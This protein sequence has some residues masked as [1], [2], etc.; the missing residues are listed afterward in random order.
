MIIFTAA[1]HGDVLKLLIQI[2]VLLTVARGLGEI[3]LRLKQPAVLGEL[4]AG[5]LLGPSCLSSLSPAWQTMFLP[6]T[7]I[8]GYL[9]EVI[10]LL[11]A[12][13][14][15]LL[16]GL[17]TDLRLIRQHSRTAMGV[18]L[19]G[20][21]VPFASGFLLGQYLPESLLVDP[22]QRV[23]F[24][25]F[26]ATAMSISAIPVLAKVLIELKMIRRDIGQIMIA[27]GMCDDTIGWALLSI[28]AGLAGGAGFQIENVAKSV[29]TVA[30]F[31]VLSFTF[32]HWLVKKALDFVQDEMTAPNRLLSLVIALTFAWGALTHSMHLEAVLGAFVMGILLGQQR[33]LPGEVIERIEGF[34]LSILAPIFFAVAGLKVNILKLASPQLLGVAFVVIFIAIAGKVIGCYLGARWIGKCDHWTSLSFGAGLNARGA[35]EIIVATIGLSLHILSQDMF[36][37]IVIMAITTSFMTPFALRW[38][39]KRVL[40]GKTELK[41]L[42]RED[43]IQKSV[44]GTIHRVLLPV[45]RRQAS[46]YAPIQSI[47]SRVL[48]NISAT[49]ELSLTL[50]NLSRPEDKEQASLF[51]EQIAPQF[52]QKEL[53]KKVV[54]GQKPVESILKEARKD[55][56]L[57]LLGATQ[58]AP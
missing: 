58:Q 44:I 2:V 34:T 53:L 23:I 9:L 52:H 49:L 35:M 6:Q 57:L 13:F 47:Q 3:M 37:I 26:M 46:L 54:E 19:G 24:A 48:E 12:M 51:L 1:P 28:V 38:T 33:R 22:Q 27:S 55:Y 11:G 8:Q 7:P 10:G 20:I 31:M 4:L 56:D 42:Q 40:P 15:L 41:R 17:E 30:L 16:T 36:S 21:L 32:G 18:S 5:V 25:F 50:F 39:L 29:G 43:W 14:L 45:R